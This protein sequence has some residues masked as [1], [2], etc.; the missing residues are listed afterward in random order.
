M[1]KSLTDWCS[2]NSSLSSRR[3]EETITAEDFESVE[4]EP[5]LDRPVELDVEMDMYVVS[6]L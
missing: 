6:A 4:P 2:I 5:P 3:S 1:L